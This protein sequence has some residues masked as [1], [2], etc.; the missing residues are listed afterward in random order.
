VGFIP[1][2][3]AIAAL[4]LARRE[5]K[6]LAYA[7]RAGIGFTERSA[8]E[9]RQVLDALATERPPVQGAPVR[10]KSTWIRPELAAAVEYTSITREGLLRHA[11]FKG[12][13]QRRGKRAL[14][15]DRRAGVARQASCYA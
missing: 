14:T 8:R 2:S 9:L 3:D 5:G 7:G 10:P 13:Q 11:S 15:V 4:H 6:A 12:L 1:A